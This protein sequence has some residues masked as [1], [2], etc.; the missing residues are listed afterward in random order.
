MS[1]FRCCS[2]RAAATEEVLQPT[3]RAR[4]RGQP[5]ALCSSRAA[6]ASL[7]LPG[8]RSAPTL[9]EARAAFQGR[10]PPV[11]ATFGRGGKVFSFLWL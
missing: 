6:R 9:P 8:R 10:H 3:R 11:A 5:S 1:R 4:G 7:W 2:A